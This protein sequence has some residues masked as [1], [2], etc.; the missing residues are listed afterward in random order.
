MIVALFE[1]LVVVG[2]TVV[3]VYAMY[4]ALSSMG[5]GTEKSVASVAGRWETAH[6]G[7][8]G[9]TKV[10]VRK[11]TPRTGRMLDEHVVAVIPDDDPDYEE[12][13]LHAMAQ[14]RSR[15]ALFDSED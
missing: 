14:A 6:Y 13:F 12:K 2:V 8:S 11:A 7:V 10:V 9:A 5:Q 15:A 1:T 3:I 4:A